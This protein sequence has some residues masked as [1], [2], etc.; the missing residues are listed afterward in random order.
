[1]SRGWPTASDTESRPRFSVGRSALALALGFGLAVIALQ[2]GVTLE[3]A[4]DE[5][6]QL[7]VRQL[8]KLDRLLQLRRDD[9]ALALPKLQS[10]VE[11]QCALLANRTM[12]RWPLKGTLVNAKPTP[13]K[14]GPV[15]RSVRS[16]A[17]S[18]T[19]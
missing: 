17:K 14:S 2:Q 18:L 9:K 5:G 11:R 15:R 10:V 16:G 3:L 4:L 12:F 7:D 13:A 1:V 19:G 6:V 8:Q